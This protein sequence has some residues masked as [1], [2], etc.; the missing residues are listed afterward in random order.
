MVRI[1]KPERV[2]AASLEDLIDASFDPRYGERWSAEQVVTALLL[3]GTSVT[4]AYAE[5]GDARPIG[6]ALVREV[7]GEA[8]LLLIAVSPTQRGKG[9]GGRLLDYAIETCCNSGNQDMF[10]EVRS[11]NTVAI[12]LYKSRGFEVVG[13]R[14]GYYR[15]D[16]GQ[17]HDALTMHRRLIES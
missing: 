14:P 7:A 9:L 16:E 12:D 5:D 10:L 17:L 3:P 13:K 2:E 1:L 8:E 6:F 11:G 15:S 4:F